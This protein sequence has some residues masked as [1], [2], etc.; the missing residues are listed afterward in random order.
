[1]ELVGAYSDRDL[2][3]GLAQEF[4]GRILLDPRPDTSHLPFAALVCLDSDRA[5]AVLS[6]DVGV[7]FCYRR[8]QKAHPERLA[9]SDGSMP[10][11]I[12]LF[13]MVRSESLSREDADAHWRDIHTPIALR[14]HQAM[15]FYTQLAIVQTIKGRVWDGI[16]LC[17]FDT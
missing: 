4:K 10:G 3:L 11:K 1:M 2:A 9:Q 15:T 12:A 6:A 14:V 17:G 13:P 7:Y 16:A 8:T 5:D